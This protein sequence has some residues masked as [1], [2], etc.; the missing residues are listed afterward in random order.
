VPPQTARQPRQT[1]LPPDSA[2]PQTASHPRSPDL[3]IHRQ[4][5]PP[6]NPA[7]PTSGFLAAEAAASATTVGGTGG[8]DPL[9]ASEIH[10]FLTCAGRPAPPPHE[11][12]LFSLRFSLLLLWYSDSVARLGPASLLGR[13]WIELW[14]LG[15]AVV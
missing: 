15:A 3:R 9:V 6:A 12:G 5:T 13:G 2:P 7:H 8:W 11:G 4:P 10:G 1:A 14:S